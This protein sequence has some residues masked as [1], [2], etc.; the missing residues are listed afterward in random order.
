MKQ[1]LRAG[2]LFAAVLAGAG[3]LAGG[4]GTAR[5]QC[6][7]ELEVERALQTIEK[8]SDVVARSDIPEAVE[9]L[10]T[11]RIRARQA[12]DRG[13]NGEREF[14]CKLA[15]V[16]QDL[17][18]RA[19]ETAE[20]GLRM[21]EQV[22][23]MLRKTDDMLREAASRVGESDAGEAMRMMGVA[24]D[25]EQE[26]WSAFRSRR[27]KLA[28]K[29]TLMARE[30]ADRALRLAEGG[31]P[32]AAGFVE[33]QL[34]RTDRLIEEAARR[35]REND[36]AAD[37]GAL[38]AGAQRLQT[39][40]K[41]QFRR[42]HPQLALGLTRQARLVV[43]RI[44]DRSDVQPETG[45]VRALIETTDALVAELRDMATDDGNERALGL[46]A[47]ADRLLQDARR[48]LDAGSPRDALTAARTA[49]ALALDVSDMLE[50]GGNEE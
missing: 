40:A 9:L 48:A 38:L 8:A 31:G 6:D 25:Q 23:Q 46:L 5:A 32:D 7:W 26:A 36:A 50:K 3:V 11:A 18:R 22:E 27:S 37:P 30:T 35:L 20:R 29:L 42:D 19:A 10:Q 41:R 24:R 14:A 12:T 39:Q 34:H 15:R 16:S 33:R 43:R 13:R 28:V 4:V 2:V 44:L 49:S 1:M 45:D 17:A 21:L 47:R